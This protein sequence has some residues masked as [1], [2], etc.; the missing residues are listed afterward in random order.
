M[1]IAG[2]SPSCASPASDSPSSCARSTGVHRTTTISSSRT[3]TGGSTG[4][5][6]ARASARAARV[7]PRGRTRATTTASG[8]AGPS[9]QA[10]AALSSGP[11]AGSR[12]ASSASTSAARTALACEEIASRRLG[13]RLVDRRAENVD[14]LV[15]RTREDECRLAAAV[16]GLGQLGDRV[17][18]RALEHAHDGHHLRLGHACRRAPPDAGTQ[19]AHVVVGEGP[20]SGHR[21]HDRVEPLAHGLG[22]VGHLGRPEPRVAADAARLGDD[23]GDQRLAAAGERGDDPVFDTAGGQRFGRHAAI[24][25]AGGSGGEAFSVQWGTKPPLRSDGARASRI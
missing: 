5:P 11:G 22:E 10:R 20:V 12:P 15:E 1:P 21:A 2:P 23:G 4:S 8:A 3:A 19:E 24:V 18:Q 16:L 14:V 7:A 25:R 17:P 6:N 9:P 13:E